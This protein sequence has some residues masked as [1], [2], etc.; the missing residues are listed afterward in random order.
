[1]IHNFLC[2]ACR[3]D[4]VCGKLPLLRKFHESAKHDLLID[5]TMERCADFLCD[6]IDGES[7][8]KIAD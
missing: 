3:H 5:L 7:D 2:D 8:E 4:L 1:M 6:E